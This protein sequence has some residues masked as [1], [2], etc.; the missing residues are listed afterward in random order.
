MDLALGRIRTACTGSRRM[1][2]VLTW[3]AR[4]QSAAAIAFVA[5]AAC[6]I[7]EPL[8]TLSPAAPNPADD[9][10]GAACVARIW[11]LTDDNTIQVLDRDRVI[12]SFVAPDGARAIAH[13]GRTRI[14][15]LGDRG[16]DAIDATNGALFE[17]T[18]D[19]TG[20]HIAVIDDRVV[21]AGDTT[22][23]FVDDGST[24]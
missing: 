19:V 7:E 5:L 3:R 14:Y 8:V 9:A 10:C 18:S 17:H 20:D 2:V 21:V 11:L 23:T 15:A 4:T 13:D 6:A 24:L 22:I 12:T 1:G 16:V